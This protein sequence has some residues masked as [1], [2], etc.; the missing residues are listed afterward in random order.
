MQLAP[1]HPGLTNIALFDEDTSKK[2]AGWVGNSKASV[3]Q[4]WLRLQF[5]V[6]TH[7]LISLCSSH[8]TLYSHT[9]YMLHMHHFSGA[10]RYTVEQLGPPWQYDDPVGDVSFRQWLEARNGPKDASSCK[11][12]LVSVSR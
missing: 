9:Y 4:V 12:Q 10:M 5:S 8:S 7:Q 3:M 2:L 1:S 6:S 11:L